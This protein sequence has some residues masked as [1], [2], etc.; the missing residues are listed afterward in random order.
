MS[1]RLEVANKFIRKGILKRIMKG[2]LE[3]H[4]NV[5]NGWNKKGS[6]TFKPPVIQYLIFFQNHISDI[7]VGIIL[8][9]LSDINCFL[10]LRMRLVRRKQFHKCEIAIS[11]C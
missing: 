3:N 5:I 6:S 1:K 11:P 4:S 10:K 8:L 7:S 2:Y 9:I